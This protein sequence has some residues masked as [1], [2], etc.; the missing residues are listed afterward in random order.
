MTG[1]SFEVADGIITGDCLLRQEPGIFETFMQMYQEHK[2]GPLAGGSLTSY[3]FM[4]IQTAAIDKL[5]PGAAS[6]F[7]RAL[8]EAEANLSD[9]SATQRA[10]FEFVARLLQDPT[11]TTGA[12]IGIPAQVNLHNGPGQIGMTTNPVEGNYLSM[13]ACLAHPLSR[14]SSHIAS[15]KLE[16]PPTIDPRYLSHP[17]DIEIYARHLMAVEVLARTEP[18]ASYLKPHGR[19][20][21][22]GPNGG[23]FDT[24]EKAKE[25]IRA[26]AL[27]NNHPVGT[28]AMLPRDMGGVVDAELNVYGVKGLRVVDSSIMPFLPRANTQTT[29]YTVAEKAADLIKK[30]HGI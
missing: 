3:A 20:A 11:Q 6:A 23:R 7:K 24:V 29:V 25:Y 21:Q 30:A 9:A 8:M 2:A 18:M 28:C 12:L 4:S 13:G 14:G 17:L 26:T 16:D 1:G 15:A 27:S 5:D 22:P 19:R 10:S